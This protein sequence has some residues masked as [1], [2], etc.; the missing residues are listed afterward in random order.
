MF[1]FQFLFLFL[2]I[3]K[4]FVM[5]ILYLFEVTLGIKD[6]T[7]EWS[8]NDLFGIG[9]LFFF[10]V[11]GPWEIVAAVSG[12]GADWIRLSVDL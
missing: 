8:L 11:L 9:L 3:L 7:F 4:L 6:V 12:R 2:V 5:L 10:V 1:L